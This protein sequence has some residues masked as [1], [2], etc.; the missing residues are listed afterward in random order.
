VLKDLAETSP[1]QKI[2][3]AVADSTSLILDVP[4][5]SALRVT[6]VLANGGQTRQS[7]EG[8]AVSIGIIGAS[9]ADSLHGWALTSSG[10]L[11]TTDGGAVWRNITPAGVAGHVVGG[12]LVAAPNIAAKQ[13]TPLEVTVAG[14]ASKPTPTKNTRMGFDISLAPGVTVMQA[15]WNSSP[16]YEIGIYPPGAVNRR[17]SDKLN[18]NLL[19]SNGPLWI[20]AITSQGWGVIPLWVGLQ[21]PC[22]DV[23]YKTF[24]L[25][26]GTASQQGATE[27]DSAVAHAKKL[28]AQLPAVIYFN[29]EPYSP[30][31]IQ[32]CSAAVQA[33]L[34]GWVS[35]LH[36]KGYTAGVYGTAA[37]V[38]NDFAQVTPLPDDVWIT[39]TVEAGAVPNV[40]IWGLKSS[41]V[42][43]C[44]PFTKS[45]C[46][47]LWNN[48]QRI[49]QYII[50]DDQAYGGQPLTVDPDVI[51]ADVA[52]SS[53]SK[54]LSY[55]FVFQNFDYPGAVGTYLRAVNN[56]GVILGMYEDSNNN[57]HG[58]TYSNGTFTDI[59]FPGAAGTYPSEI[60]D[61]GQIV[62]SYSFLTPTGETG[63]LGFT[64]RKGQ[65]A[66]IAQGKATLGAEANGID[67]GGLIAG[68]YY[69][70]QYVEHGYVKNPATGKFITTGAATSMN[71]NAY[72][73]SS[74]TLFDLGVSY[75]AG[76]YLG[77]VT[78][79][80]GGLNNS[81]LLMCSNF[82]YD[83]PTMNSEM[84]Q[85]TGPTS[86]QTYLI[87]VNDFAEIV[88][89]WVDDNNNVH[90]LI[91]TPQ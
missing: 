4:T 26:T 41:G 9:F 57:G 19:G 47:T 49:H 16:Y 66:T 29:M 17:K 13:T 62:G 61:A 74:N 79:D 25:D 68:W 88:G 80:C 1:G 6:S 44:D 8:G 51:D 67:D 21:A 3:S 36:A 28:S 73:F 71:N 56:Y 90:G 48:S 84:L 60:N 34:G 40:S 12:T 27:A 50:E 65:Y 2:T 52:I 38:A 55:S 76:T 54:W 7:A 37:E 5:K 31:T 85:Y 77:P 70:S 39:A 18:V 59:D 82:A 46:P 11:S 64:L 53:S 87:G 30:T 83:I 23:K 42:A 14:Q 91:G 72:I 69:D 24:S 81:L 89:Y 45:A 58:F 63:L 10:L 75:L 33:F 86:I 78:N 15:W 32:G 35:E 43:L 22:V 20:S